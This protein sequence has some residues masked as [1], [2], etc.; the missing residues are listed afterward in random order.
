MLDQYKGRVEIQTA[1]FPDSISILP[2][3]FI[4]ET[5]LQIAGGGDAD[6]DGSVKMEDIVKL[7]TNDEVSCENSAWFI[8]HH[9]R[10]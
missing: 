4:V 1:G 3:C 5:S 10:K 9:Y 7:H 2:L 6:L 8:T